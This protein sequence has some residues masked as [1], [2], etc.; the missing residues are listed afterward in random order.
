MY[1]FA[2]GLS[3]TPYKKSLTW[4]PFAKSS[5]RGYVRCNTKELSEKNMNVVSFILRIT[6]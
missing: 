4:T 6:N 1:T 3:S 2:D 5:S